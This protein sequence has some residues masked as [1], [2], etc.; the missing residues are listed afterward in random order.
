MGPRPDGRGKVVAALVL[1]VVALRQWGRGQTAAESCRP[2]RAVRLPNRVNGAAARRPR[3]GDLDVYHA[4][5]DAASMGPRPDGRGKRCAP[6]VRLNSTRSVNGAAARRPR[7]GRHRRPAHN[8]LASRQ[9]GRG[10]TAAESWI[11]CSTVCRRNR[12][13]GAAAR[14]PR[15]GLCAWRRHSALQASMGP[16][17]DGR[18][19]LARRAAAGPEFCVNGAAARRPRKVPISQPLKRCGFTGVNG[20]AARRPRKDTLRRLPENPSER[21]W[22]RGQTAAESRRVYR[23]DL[24][25]RSASMGPRPDGRGKYKSR[26]RH[27]IKPQASMGPRPDGRGKLQGCTVFP[28]HVLRQ[29]G[30]GQTAAESCYRGCNYFTMLPRQW[31]RGQTAAE[32][33]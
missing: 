1:V 12:V 23:E 7:K 20:A 15:K 24:S 28:T 22:G 5:R 18:G 17:P 4:L 25:A 30:R 21:Q 29:W 16:R 2:T 3:K 32:R 8:G 14:R 9:W 10:Q 27:R 6:P 31:G 26:A 33:T 13:N 19:K 11:S